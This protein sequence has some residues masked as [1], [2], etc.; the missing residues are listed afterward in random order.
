M[1]TGAL[2]VTVGGRGRTGFGFEFPSEK[3]TPLSRS[4]FSL[5]E[6]LLASVL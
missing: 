3:L 5:C 6:K 1:R 4:I 2:P